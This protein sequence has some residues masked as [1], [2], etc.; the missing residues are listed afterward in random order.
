MDVHPP[1]NGIFIGIDPYPLKRSAGVISARLLP[2]AL[3]HQTLDA[4][5][6]SQHL[7]NMGSWQQIQQFS[8]GK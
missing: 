4:V 2:G 1:K 3:V 5:Q 7:L 8:Q 6:P